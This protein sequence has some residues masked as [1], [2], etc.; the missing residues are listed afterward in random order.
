MF[1]GFLYNSMFCEVFHIFH[2]VFHIFTGLNAPKTRGFCDYGGSFPHFNPHNVENFISPPLY[3]KRLK[4][5]NFP[6]HFS[7]FD[8]QSDEIH[9]KRY[10]LYLVNKLALLRLQRATCPCIQ[11]LVSYILH[12]KFVPCLSTYHSRIVTAKRQW[13]HIQ[14]DRM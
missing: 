10:C 9:R 13:R 2:R 11:C 1:C 14:F 8:C 12:L 7:L 3:T 5:G 6:H 4:N